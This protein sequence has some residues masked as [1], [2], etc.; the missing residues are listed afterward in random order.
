MMQRILSGEWPVCR[1]D[2]WFADRYLAGHLGIEIRWNW[3][4]YH[5]THGLPVTPWRNEA[6]G[7]IQF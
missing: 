7:D 4:H 5:T 6:M 1:V 2:C 3:Q